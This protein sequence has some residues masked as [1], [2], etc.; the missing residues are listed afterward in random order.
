MHSVIARRGSDQPLVV[1]LPA[2]DLEAG[3]ARVAVTAAAFTY[4]DAFV[5]AHLDLFGLPEQVGLGFDFAG[6]VVEV[7][8]GVTELAVGDRVAGLH[9]DIAAPVRAHTEELVIASEAL[10]VVPDALDLEVAAAVPL[11]ALTARQAL[12]LLGPDRGRLLVTG[13][14][15]AIGGWLLELADT[16]GWQ[17]T[18]LVR[19][20]TEHLVPAR[21]T[22]TELTG[23]YD[24]VLDAAA[25]HAPALAAVA[26]GGRY[27]GF[28]PNQA[29]PPE[30]DI[31]VSTVQVQPD[32]QSLAKLLTLAADGVVPV[33]IAGRASLSDAAVVY[34]RGSSESGSRGRWLLVP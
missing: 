18:A 16:E 27:V 9:V 5:A 29:Q 22:V 34:A 12:D 17:V 21:A 15:G 30:R 32:G 31:T 20:G 26:D 2:Q 11:S 19:P 3:Q 1:D 14:A 8:A 28:K 10:A 23:T 24:A 6:T 7:G 13:A 25:L 4:F 33:R